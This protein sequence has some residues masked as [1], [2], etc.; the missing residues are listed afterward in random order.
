LG[1]IAL[2]AWQ[3]SIAA[4]KPGGGGAG[5]PAPTPDIL[6]M[7]D[8][9]STQA[10]DQSAVRGIALGSDGVSGT[11]L[12]LQ[13]AR[14]GRIPRSVAWSPD[15]TRAAWF[16]LGR[17][18]TATPTSIMVGAPSG[19][20]TAVFASVPGDGNPDV[21]TVTDGL[22]WA[23]DCRDPAKSVLVFSSTSP[24]GI[25]AIRFTNG[26]PGA[27]VQ[28][29]SLNVGN[30]MW[31]FPTAFAF[32][33]TGRHLAFAGSGATSEYGVW[34]LD[35]CTPDL[36]PQ[37][38]LTAVQVGGTG[39]GPVVSMD[40]SR[41]GERL[42]LSVTVGAE[43]YPWRDLKI[44]DLAYTFD[45]K[46]E[47]VSGVGVWRIDLDS[48][49]GTASSEHSP[50]WGPAAAG[51]ACERIAFS[52]SSDVAPR[53]LYLLD[54]KAGATATCGPGTLRQLSAKYPRALDWK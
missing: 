23:P 24:A 27:P 48:V 6:Y 29:F 8:D 35:M 37:M 53:R 1:S 17:S 36:P 30:G 4:G 51:A 26:Q 2:A 9:G 50:Q 14:A 41:H 38:L 49:F 52:Q 54:I 46:T 45:G 40:W 34:L 16:E 5:T 15:G 32:S 31:F 25:F 47:A 13:S 28:L 39:L 44:A 21:N 18:M 19:K 20:A 42:A 43:P 33:P 11:D 22:A 7:S 12:S 3:P 10:L